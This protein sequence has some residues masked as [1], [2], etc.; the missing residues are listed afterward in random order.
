MSRLVLVHWNAAEAR[1]RARG[2][3]RLGH[4][5]RCLTA[6]SAP[7]LRALREDPPDVFV[8]SLERVPSAGR[9]VAVGL[10]QQKGTRLVPIVFVPGDPEKTRKT[11]ALLPDTV[12]SEWPRIGA[13][14]KEALVTAPADPVVPGA[15]A[16]YRGA[17][18]AKKLGIRGGS[19][20]LL[21]GAPRGF[22]GLLGPLPKGA[23]IF[24]SGWAQADVLLL[25]I[26]SLPDLQALVPGAARSLAPGGKL[27]IVWPKKT[28]GKATGP[29]QNDVR[30]F[31]LASGFVDYKI[32]ALDATWSGLCFARRRAARG[33]R[34]GGRGSP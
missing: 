15:M 8:I 9:D 23:R 26:R 33:G 19:R 27:W 5:V 11:H 17:P 29:G 1:E 24:S 20:I 14:I 4:N 7:E 25:V 3:E 32:A 22:R 21:V 12:I 18:L 10:R 16:G 30:A 28:S 2:I 6:P 34:A 13:A 31:G